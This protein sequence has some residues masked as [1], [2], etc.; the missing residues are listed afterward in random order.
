[1]KLLNKHDRDPGWEKIIN[2]YQ[3]TQ[4]EIIAFNRKENKQKDIDKRIDYLKSEIQH[5][6]LTH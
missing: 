3:P 1:M 5:K 4:E 6:N 2:V